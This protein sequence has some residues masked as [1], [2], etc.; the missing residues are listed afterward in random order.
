[1][2]CWCDTVV[3]P[4]AAEAAGEPFVRPAAHLAPPGGHTPAL[5]GLELFT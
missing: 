3:G 1:V 2:S 4:P 5:L